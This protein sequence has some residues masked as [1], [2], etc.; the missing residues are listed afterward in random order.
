[1]AILRFLLEILHLWIWLFAPPPETRSL[2][3]IS[4]DTL[5]ADRL[6]CYGYQNNRTPHFDLWASEGFLFEQAYSEYPLTLP[7]HATMLTGQ[8][9]PR[10]GVRENAGFR[11]NSDQTTLA[12]VLRDHKYRTAAFIGSYVLASE[13]G[14]SQGFE[15]FDESFATS[16]ENGGASTE[17][18]RSAPEV[19]TRFLDWLGHNQD[20]AFFAFVH[21]Y[22][23]HMPRPEGY[24]PEVS[25][26]DESLGDIDRFLREN[27]LLRKTDIILTSDHGESLGDHGEAGH[28][29]FVYDSTLHVP[30]IVRPAGS[31]GRRGT[32]IQHRVSL[33]D[34]M[35]TILGRLNI[36]VPSSVQGRSLRP[37]LSNQPVPEAPLY[38]ECFVPELHFGWS[39]LQSLRLGRYKYIDAAKPELY[40]I[41]EDRG[42]LRNLCSQQPGIAA[43]YH[44]KLRHFIA[45]YG[46][47]RDPA[48]PRQTDPDTLRKLMALGYLNTGSA[49]K[50]QSA[51]LIDPKDRIAVFEQYHE[52]LNHLSAGR[53]HPSLFEAIRKLRKAAPEVRGITYLQAWG[54]E[55]SGNL[56]AARENYQMAVKE[57]PDN[58]MARSRYAT[59]LIKLQE[60]EE[61]E[62]QLKEILRGVPSDYKSRNNLAGLYWMTGRREQAVQEVK[63]ITRARPDYLAAWQNLGRLQ[64]EAGNWR[65][66]EL[67]FLRVTQLDPKNAAAYLGLAYALRA[68]GRPEEADR[69]EEQAYLVNPQL[70]RK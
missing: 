58:A 62:R 67:A 26:V 6:S 54:F 53:L 41:L 11:L 27:D 42:E 40:D 37:A 29:F 66:A 36:D 64:A 49:K 47:G 69:Q 13:F 63:G 48:A 45:D 9:P 65:E 7:A 35:P 68:Q 16:I 51:A 10:H 22:D 24:D 43:D 14:V 23:P 4:V 55:L 5:R 34:L 31:R 61:A 60:L 33:A 15:T 46:A 57:Q 70:R 12:E 19:T 21:F 17:V 20:Q 8:I 44:K 2:I 25:R 30:L 18:Q 3:L 28:G 38:S 39:P 1:M 32:R 50:A 52:V 56:K 59:L